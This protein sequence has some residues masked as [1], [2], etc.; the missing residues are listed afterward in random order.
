MMYANWGLGMGEY[1]IGH[2][3]APFI[4]K[5][6]THISKWKIQP[7]P[8]KSFFNIYTHKAGVYACAPFEVILMDK[9]HFSKIYD[10][11]KNEELNNAIGKTI[12]IGRISG[13]LCFL[14][15][16]WFAYSL[17]MVT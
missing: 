14:L 9:T 1:T 3:V 15:A 7:Y 4:K 5:K 2:W 6:D 16:Y 10:D 8:Q 17:V 11:I 12:S 13:G